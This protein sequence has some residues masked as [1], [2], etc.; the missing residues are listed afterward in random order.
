MV[1]I[2]VHYEVAWTVLSN[3]WPRDQPRQRSATRSKTKR[4]RIQPEFMDIA[5]REFSCKL[6]QSLLTN[7]HNISSSNAFSAQC[8][9]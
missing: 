8:R 9:S 1:E 2:E 4:K 5:P 3:L 7:H 6:K